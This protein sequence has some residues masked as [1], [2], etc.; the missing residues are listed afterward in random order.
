MEMD[1]LREKMP[2]YIRGAL[3]EREMLEISQALADSPDAMDELRFTLMMRQ[4]FR[5]DAAAL[6]PFPRLPAGQEQ[7]APTYIPRSLHNSLALLQNAASVTR[8]AVRTA[9]NFL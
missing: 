5:P 6:P 8:S 2:R 4:A 3:P 9:F 7:P 1:A